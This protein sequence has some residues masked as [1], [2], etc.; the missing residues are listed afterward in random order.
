MVPDHGCGINSVPDSNRALK[1][2]YEKQD[3]EHKYLLA[4]SKQKNG[5]SW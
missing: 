1:K 3:G 4:I 5:I 2:N